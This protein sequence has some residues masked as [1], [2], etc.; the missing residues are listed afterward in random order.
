VF[1]AARSALLIGGVSKAEQW[2]PQCKRD[3]GIVTFAEKNRDKVC[4][5]VLFVVSC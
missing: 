3:L 1:A 4:S 2:M 5:S